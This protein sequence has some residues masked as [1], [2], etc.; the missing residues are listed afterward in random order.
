MHIFISALS[1]SSLGSYAHFRLRFSGKYLFLFIALLCS[2]IT[3]AQQA[4]IFGKITDELNRPLEFVNLSI[5]GQSGGTSTAR[6]GSY[7]LAIPASKPCRLVISSLG[8]KSDTL[9]FELSPGEKRRIDHQLNEKA[10]QLGSITIEDKQLRNSNLNRLNPKAAIALPSAGGGIESLLKTM[11][12]V[13]SNNELS[14]QYS[15][16]GGN[17]DENLVYVNDI[18]IYRPFLVRS[19]QQEGLSFLNSDLVSSVLFSA[20][21]FDAKYGDKLSSALDIRYKHPSEFAASASASLLGTNIHVEGASDNNRFTYLAGARYK[22]SQYL[23]NGLDTKGSYRPVFLDLQSL[24]TYDINEELEL[25]VLAYLSSNSYTLVPE[26]RETNFGTLYQPLRLNIYFDGQELDR[27]RSMMGAVTLTHKPNKNLQ[28][29]WITSAYRSLEQE[30]FDIQAQYWIGLLENQPADYDSIEVIETK[31]VG[32][33]INHARNKLAMTVVNI[34]NRYSLNYRNSF[35]QWGFKYQHEFINDKLKE[36]YMVDSA[37]Y[38]LPYDPG[39]LGQ[40][41]NLDDLYLSYH[42]QSEAKLSTN[43]YTAFAQNTWDFKSDSSHLALTAGVRF[44]Y[45]DYNKQFL[46][47]PRATLSYKPN[48]KKDILFRF[49]TGYYYQPPFYRELRNLEDSIN[50]N[51]KAQKSIHFVLGS[52]LNFQAWDRRFKF[53][54]EVYYKYMKDLV[55]Y[56]VDNVRIRYLGINGSKG[57]AAGIDMKVNG[58]FVKGIESWASLSIMKTAEDLYDDSYLEYY[59][60]AGELIEAGVDQDKTIKDTLTVYPGFI[61]RPTDQ[62]ITFGLFFQDYLPSNPTYKMNL[63]AYFGSGLPT[64]APFTP[65][66]THTHR[67]SQYV[68][69]D[70]GLSKQLIGQATKK[71]L[72]TFFKG[73]KALWASLEVLN[74]LQVSNT[75]SYNW[76]RDYNGNQYGVPNYLTPRQVNVKLIAEF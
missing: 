14:S 27:Y 63:G 70:I 68:R 64:G 45:W 11:P 36:W 65:I 66:Y 13:V 61:P 40:S 1:K 47:S 18:E 53:V 46:A 59:N 5:L 55:P 30:S 42:V 7:S 33:Y 20:G 50:P 16:R 9:K 24:L 19:G 73:F 71:P 21:G 34:E 25:S 57:Y 28:V 75:I 35:A 67:M 12:G 58:E 43:R 44:Q 31:G 51:L 52:D 26:S 62:R 6:D 41:G 2:L 49:S 76:V 72:P 32:N 3:E 56:E 69:V 37:G 4:S 74:L 15:V 38:S 48:W 17:F 39:T 10:V 54:T 8:Y 29:K 22:T 23:L 60:P